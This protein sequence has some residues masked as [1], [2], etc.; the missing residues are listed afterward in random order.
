MTHAFP[1]PQLFAE[2]SDDELEVDGGIAPLAVGLAV[3]GAIIGT[4]VAIGV[5]SDAING[6]YDLCTGW[7]N[8]EG[9]TP[10]VT[11]TIY[12]PPQ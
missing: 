5:A 6:V 9:S 11:S 2:L 8:Y 12:Y 3:Y 10:H 4:V 7:N 1:T